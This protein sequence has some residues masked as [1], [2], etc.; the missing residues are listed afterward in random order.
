MMR[1]L[2]GV[3]QFSGVDIWTVMDFL[4]DIWVAV[5]FANYG[6]SASFGCSGRL[7]IH[8]DT[9]FGCCSAVLSAMLM[10]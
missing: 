7:A 9:V 3:V 10:E 8:V 6:N 4:G 1:V 2:V 5:A